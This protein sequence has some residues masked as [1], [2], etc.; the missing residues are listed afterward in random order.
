MFL[1]G[2]NDFLFSLKKG[3]ERCLGAFALI[4]VKSLR[5]VLQP[6]AVYGR[7]RNPLYYCCCW[8]WCRFLLWVSQFVCSLHFNAV[9]HA[10]LCSS[11]R[12]LCVVTL[13]LL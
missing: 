9:Q 11:F 13:S 6:C 12:G 8:W 4:K 1:I 7:S 5:P 3:K 2:L 10:E